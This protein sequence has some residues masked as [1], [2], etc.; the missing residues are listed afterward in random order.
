MFA[1]IDITQ[2]SVSAWEALGGGESARVKPNPLTWMAADAF[3]FCDWFGVDRTTA[4]EERFVGLINVL[5][6]DM[7]SCEF[8]FE[9]CKVAESYNSQQ[10]KKN[11]RW[12]LEHGWKKP[13]PFSSTAAGSYLQT[14]YS[15]DWPSW[16]DDDFADTVRTCKQNPH[17]IGNPRYSDMEMD[18]SLRYDDGLSE[19]MEDSV[20]SDVQRC[21]GG[22]FNS[23]PEAYDLFVDEAWK[24]GAISGFMGQPSHELRLD[25]PVLAAHQWTPLLKPRVE[26]VTKYTHHS[27]TVEL[28]SDSK[29]I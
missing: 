9:H 28:K 3:G 19:M 24:P 13:P 5:H 27:W 8:L 11:M 16:W 14:G 25:S 20:H 18:M 12:F 26:N 15:D 4:P 23:V 6:L 7:S 22:E 1:T 21:Y 2:P 10:G 29:E 17:L